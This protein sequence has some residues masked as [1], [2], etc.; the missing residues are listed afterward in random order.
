MK[1]LVVI[2]SVL[3]VLFSSC[4]NE[5]KA[6]NNFVG[7]ISPSTVW[8]S[9]PYGIPVYCY[10]KGFDHP[11]VKEIM[12][13]P[14]YSMNFEYERIKDAQYVMFRKDGSKDPSVVYSRLDGTETWVLE[15][16]TDMNPDE[17]IS[18]LKKYNKQEKEQQKIHEK[19]AKERAELEKK[20][21]VLD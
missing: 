1:R 15:K 10:Y 21:E 4:N 19:K 13:D 2:L 17:A 20:L 18:M 6:L 8:T 11:L 14:I 16:S 9:C 12:A 5:Q 7:N 3:S